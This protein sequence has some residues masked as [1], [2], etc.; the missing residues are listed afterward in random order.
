MH[1]LEDLPS[2]EYLILWSAY[3]PKS[4]LV[5]G[6]YRF[7]F[8]FSNLESMFGKNEN[9]KGYFNYTEAIYPL[10]FSKSLHKVFFYF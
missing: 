2:T 4:A 8:S 9:L 5:Q 3:E 10:Y 7:S 6:L 1:Y